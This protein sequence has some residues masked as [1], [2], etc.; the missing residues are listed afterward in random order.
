MSERPELLIGERRLALESEETVLDGLIR[1]GVPVGSSCRAGHCFS[2]M[3]RG[4]QPPP[5]AQV[6]L[7]RTLVEQG[8]FLACQA[9]P[10][11]PLRILETAA[12]TRLAK[13]V[14]HELIG[15]EIVRLRLRP[16]PELDYRP[17]QFINVTTPDGL[18]RS[19][20]LASIPEEE[21]LELH[22]REI[23]GGRVSGWLHRSVSTGDQLAIAG[24]H[25]SCFYAGGQMDQP[26]IL[27]GA[28]TGL[29][30]LYGIVRDA[31]MRGHR[32]PIHLIQ[33]ARTPD[34]LYHLEEL[35]ELEARWET[36]SLHLCVL[37]GKAA[38]VVSEGLDS[39]AT[40]LA[41]D[42]R[43]ADQSSPRAFLCGDP[44]LVT[45][46]RRALFL[47]GVPSADILAD[48]FLPSASTTPAPS[49]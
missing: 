47:G 19:Y 18:I 23:P 8:F 5:G 38:G 10:E 25:G 39:R 35:R 1:H 32:G 48:P 15:E 31:L 2:C 29:A 28:G 3:V 11:G 41:S 21:F 40:Q 26:L 14:G 22:V 37:E 17:G 27:A 9:R 36:L 46:L 20:S 49:G 33:G 44:P 30:P 43:K 4:E 45:A 16:D 34:R 13:V 42:L 7:K 12:E 6:G 24:P